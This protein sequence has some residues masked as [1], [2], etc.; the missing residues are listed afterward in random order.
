MMKTFNNSPRFIS[1]A[2]TLVKR[3]LAN[4]WSGE[5][6]KSRGDTIIEVMLAIVLIGSAVTLAVSMSHHDLNVGID[7]TQRSQALSAAQSQIERL[8]NAYINSDPVLTNYKSTQPFCILDNGTVELA[9]TPNS[10]CTNFDS[11]QYSLSIKYDDSLISFNVTATWGSNANGSGQDQLSLYYKLPSTYKE[12]LVITGAVTNQTQ[13]SATL[14]GS[15]NPNG[16]VVSECY[17]NYGLTASYGSRADC[18][19]LPAGTSGSQAVSA[20]A[21]GLIP[22]SIY[23]VELCASNKVLGT[24]CGSDINFSTAVK[25]TTTT[26]SASSVGQTSATLNG[27]VNPNGSALTACYFDLGTTVSYGSRVACSSVPGGASGNQAASGSASGLVSNTGYHFRFCAGNVA[28]TNCGSDQ[29]FTT[30]ASVP[31]I[32]FSANRTSISYKDTVTLTWSATNAT[33]CTASGPWSTSNKTSGNSATSPLSAN[34]TL[35]LSCSGSG[36]TAN[37]TPIN[38]S[39]GPNGIYGQYYQGANFNSGPMTNIIDSLIDNYSVQGGPD[40][41]WLSRLRS[42]TGLSEASCVSVRWTGQILADNAGSYL[43]ETWSDDGIIVWIDGNAIINNWTQHSPTW[44]SGNIG[45][46]SGWHSIR[47]DY[48]N[49]NGDGCHSGNDYSA[50][51]QL[52][53]TNPTSGRNQVP[54]DHLRPW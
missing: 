43:F 23:H 26:Q 50:V 12:A 33:S 10:K 34:T 11:S 9:S 44:N 38:V 27:T 24:S 39:V 52:V 29:T 25:P 13:T 46:S 6:H 45:L 40:N 15:V 31:S 37:A 19:S 20:S 41:G 18:S 8:R 42:R 1:D 2:R 5:S 21:S 47:V 17:F 32:T 22:N 30:T 35:G 53:W 51:A 49:N 7:S 14:N 16:V 36:G 28:G 54:P 3:C 4:A 48:Q